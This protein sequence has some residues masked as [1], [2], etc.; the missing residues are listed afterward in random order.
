MKKIISILLIVLVIGCFGLDAKTTKKSNIKRSNKS[1][2]VSKTENTKSL[3]SPIISPFISY[4][5]GSRVI[6]IPDIKAFSPLLSRFEN[7]NEPLKRITVYYMS[8]EGGLGTLDEDLTDFNNANNITTAKKYA[9]SDIVLEFNSKQLIT[10]IDYSFGNYWFKYDDKGHP[11]TITQDEWGYRGSPIFKIK[12]NI[13]WQDD[14]PVS[15]TRDIIE[16]ESIYGEGDGT[17][18]PFD[19]DFAG[20]PIVSDMLSMLKSKTT[21]CKII[22]NTC[23]ISGRTSLEHSIFEKGDRVVYWVEV[24]TGSY[25]KKSTSKASPPSKND[26]ANPRARKAQ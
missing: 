5:V 9:T 10:H 26:S 19:L 7:S 8:G 2:K 12:Y 3:S 23:R 4:R 17:S 20:E 14:K 6:K 24:N 13:R 16:Y 11:I 1:S 21:E 15:I 18:L 25:E 22:Q